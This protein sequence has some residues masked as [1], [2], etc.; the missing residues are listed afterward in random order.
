MARKHH[1]VR[2]AVSALAMAATALLGLP[3]AAHADTVLTRSEQTT[4]EMSTTA[5]RPGDTVTFTVTVTNDTDTEKGAL[6]SLQ[7]S[8]PVFSPVVDGNCVIE[9]G[10]QPDQC[11]IAPPDGGGSLELDHGYVSKPPIDPHSS[12]KVSLTT[13]VA[14][15][16]APGAYTLTASGEFDFEPVDFSPESPTFTVLGADADLEVGLNAD[17]A[18]LSPQ[19]TYTQTV[20]NNGPATVTSG[21]VTTKLPAQ[22]ASVS[23]LPANCAFTPGA[24]SVTCTLND[25]ANGSTATHTFTAKMNLTSLGSLPATATRTTSTPTDPNPAN[26]TATATC[27][28]VTSLIINC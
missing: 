22:T 13:T 17:P 21:T 11:R 24:K 2:S 10:P 23:G 3:Q 20:T 8:A 19:V 4:I 18:P 14:K 7:P 5:A 1:V 15:D 26:D 27:T 6:L 28:A 25:L 16:A 9:S 12:A